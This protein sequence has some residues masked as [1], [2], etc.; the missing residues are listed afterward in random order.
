MASNNGGNGARPLGAAPL[1][2]ARGPAE[3]CAE[4]LPMGT[5]QG[6]LPGTVDATL[7]RMR[8][9]KPWIRRFVLPAA[10]V[11]ATALSWGLLEKTASAQV[12]EVAPPAVRVE[13]VPVRPSPHHFWIGG[14]WGWRAGYGHVWVPGRWEVARHGYSWTPARWTREGGHWRFAEGHWHRHG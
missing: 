14:H 10:V 13:V 1:A 4:P 11:T 7:P 12:V 2:G 3:A 8:N 9:L 6:F 5:A